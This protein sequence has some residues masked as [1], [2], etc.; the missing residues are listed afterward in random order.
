MKFGENLRNFRKDS[1][2]TAKQFAEMLGL[3]YPTY[4]QYENAKRQPRF[5]MLCKMADL[6]GA[7]TD[8]LLGHRGDRYAVKY[9][10]LKAAIL[11]TVVEV[12]KEA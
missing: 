11:S 10:R 6:L 7:T 2:Y 5:E 8:D 1:G 3:N 4:I 9:L 12:D